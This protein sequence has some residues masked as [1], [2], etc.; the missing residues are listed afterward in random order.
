M[1]GAVLARGYDMSA[2]QEYWKECMAIA[3]EECGLV[4]TDSQLQ[5]LASAAEDGHE[6]Y[7][8]SFYSPS[9]SEVYAPQIQQL[10]REL[11]KERSLVHCEPCKGTGRLKYNTG[12]WGVNTQ[13]DTC[14]GAGEHA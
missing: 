6:G 9:S 11:A 10:E 8:L 13:C 12:S 2:E 3:A 14:N 1:A 4:L 7:G 5:H